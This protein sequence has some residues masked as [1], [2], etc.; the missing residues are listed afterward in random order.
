[1]I[2]D[3]LKHAN[4]E[5]IAFFRVNTAGMKPQQQN[6]GCYTRDFAIKGLVELGF[7]CIQSKC[8]SKEIGHN[9]IRMNSCP[10]G[11]VTRQILLK[12]CD[13]VLILLQI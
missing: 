1:M 11:T 12:V 7:H 5:T 3:F 8:G 6:V 2:L 4:N 9:I 10:Y 13:S